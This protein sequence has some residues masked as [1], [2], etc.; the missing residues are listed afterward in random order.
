[1][2]PW[3]TLGIE[4]TTDQ[5]AIKRAYAAKLKRTRPDEN[6]QGFQQLHT[7]Y[8]W[9]ADYARSQAVEPQPE[10]RPI[11][12]AATEVQPVH[13][14]PEAQPQAVDE[15][16]YAASESVESVQSIPED[17]S[18]RDEVEDADV[19][20]ADRKQLE[21]LLNTDPAAEQAFLQEEWYRLTEAA[22]Q[23][24]ASI[25][26]L[27]NQASWRFLENRQALFDL[28]LKYEYSLYLFSRIESLLRDGNSKPMIQQE[29][30]DHL[31][32]LFRWRD[33][34]DLLEEEL[35]YDEVDRVFQSIKG[36]APQHIKWTSPKF[37]KG[38]L[39]YA[40]YF[41]KL[42]ATLFDW[43][44]LVFL[45]RI[46]AKVGLPII[47]TSEQNLIQDLIGAVVLYLLMTP[48]MES[49]PLQGTLGKILF[50]IKVVNK[51]GR[52]LNILHAT[53]RTLLFTLSTAGF[54]ATVWVNLFI[55]DGRL[56]HDRLSAS[57][58]VKR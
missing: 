41:V 33:S 40:N 19:Q 43:V 25:G 36:S 35:G 27:N 28:Q 44:I 18:H 21:E 57:M 20:D 23:A 51:R 31:D 48:I 54:K 42:V 29:I 52:R 22:D 9:A 56:L 5:R 7:A 46:L 3:R 8:R 1:M 11:S 13:S 17:A 53:L 50:G 2:N 30:F 10:N 24:T 32:D 39:V 38:E 4:P 58:V 16:P 12:G 49:M 14:Q 15:P 37:H 6:P 47:G 26:N 45:A 34:R 55:N